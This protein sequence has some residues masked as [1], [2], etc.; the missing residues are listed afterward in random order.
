MRWAG[1]GWKAGCQKC[2]TKLLPNLTHK[3]SIFDDTD[4]AAML[5]TRSIVLESRAGDKLHELKV[6]CCCGAFFFCCD[7]E[8]NYEALISNHDL[9]KKA[10]PGFYYRSGTSSIVALGEGA[11]A[12][13]KYNRL[14]TH[15]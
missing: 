7:N 11:S 12:I 13:L 9:V 10:T 4:A 3:G 15:P 14:L 1:D 2:K 6:V 8:R 5:S